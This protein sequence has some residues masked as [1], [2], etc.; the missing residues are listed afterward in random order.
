MLNW[1]NK[2]VGR[3]NLKTLGDYRD[4]VTQLEVTYRYAWKIELGVKAKNYR[5]HG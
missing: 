2:R 1:I 3:G 5:T 4:N